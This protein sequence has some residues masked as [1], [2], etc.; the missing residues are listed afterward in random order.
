MKPTGKLVLLVVL[1]AFNFGAFGIGP[2]IG[3]EADH[4]MC[5]WCAGPPEPH[6]CCAY[7]C[8]SSCDCPEGAG[9]C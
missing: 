3:E 2:V 5:T 9:Q 6:I 7:T 1:T 4:W 8:S